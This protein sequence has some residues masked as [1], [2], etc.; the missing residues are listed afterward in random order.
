[1]GETGRQ[2]AVGVDLREQQPRL[3]LDASTASSPAT[4]RSGGSSLSASS[5]SAR[6]SLAGSPA[7]WPFIACQAG[8]V[9]AVR[10]A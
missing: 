7:C 2:L 5:T 6:A 8:I 9:C 10:S 1:V 4:Q 3:L